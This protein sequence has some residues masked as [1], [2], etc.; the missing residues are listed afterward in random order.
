MSALATL[1]ARCIREAG[2]LGV[3]DYMEMVLTHPEHGYYTTRDPLGARGDFVTAPEVSQIFGEL[4]GLWC[5]DN[6]LR[7]GRPDP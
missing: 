3:D 5:A 4:I 2:P 7:M 1:L 6:W